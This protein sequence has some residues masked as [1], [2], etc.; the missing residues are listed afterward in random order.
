MRR[1]VRPHRVELDDA[2]W[3]RLQHRHVLR[4]NRGTMISFQ[5]AQAAIAGAFED[6]ADPTNYSGADQKGSLRQW[7]IEFTGPHSTA[8]R[9]AQKALQ[10]QR[11]AAGTWRRV[12]ALA[13]DGAYEQVS[14]SADAS[15]QQLRV[16]Q[17][18]RRIARSLCER[19]PRAMGAPMVRREGAVAV[20]WKRVARLGSPRR[21]EDVVVEWNAEAI[22]KLGSALEEAKQAVADSGPARASAVVFSSAGTLRIGTWN[23]RALLHGV[24][25]TRRQ[26]LS[27]LRGVVLRCALLPLYEV[28]VKRS[29]LHRARATHGGVDLSH[30]RASGRGDERHLV[31]RGGSST[32]EERSRCA[33]IIMAHGSRW[34]SSTATGRWRRSTVE[35]LDSPATKVAFVVGDFNYDAADC[36]WQG[37]RGAPCRPRL[38]PRRHTREARAFAQAVKAPKGRVLGGDGSD[39][40]G[41]NEPWVGGVGAVVAWLVSGARGTTASSS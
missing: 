7:T 25:G 17:A 4:A 31:R 35:A 38:A 22:E 18:G 15:P 11:T 13:P 23:A 2:E 37:A 39:S 27:G 26:K 32:E 16:E 36:D 6:V 41:K 19:L 21:G 5:S 10:V 12:D 24:P 9:R 14:V 29:A 28:H 33:L 20:E 3:S 30:G 8:A 34:W 40:R 1:R